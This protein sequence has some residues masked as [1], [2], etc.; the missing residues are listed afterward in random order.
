MS[1][2]LVFHSH[3]TVYKGNYHQASKR[4][5]QN[6]GLIRRGSVCQTYKLSWAFLG[7]GRCSDLLISDTGQDRHL[8]G[9]TV[10]CF[11][12]FNVFFLNFTDRP[13][14]F[15]GRGQFLGE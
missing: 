11:R 15:E 14:F 5:S 10:L 7:W 8:P 3:P 9:V 1:F 4:I 13:L 2:Y 6:P 12:Q